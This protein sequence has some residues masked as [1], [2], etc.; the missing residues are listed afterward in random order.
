MKPAGN[1]CIEEQTGIV[2]EAQI[3]AVIGGEE[4]SALTSSVSSDF[5]SSV[6][7][8]YTQKMFVVPEAASGA[9]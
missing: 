9:E 3:G 7:D 8:F 5:S 2:G 1:L 6:L 4:R